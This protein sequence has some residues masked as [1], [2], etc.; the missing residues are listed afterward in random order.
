M[1]Q[2]EN[3]EWLREI[4]EWTYIHPS[5]QTRLY[6]ARNMHAPGP[7]TPKHAQ[8]VHASYMHP[9]IQT[10]AQYVYIYVC[11]TYMLCAYYPP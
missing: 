7:H 9:P 5:T 11:A 10:P 2:S 4:A 8:I 3:A 1:L 6:C